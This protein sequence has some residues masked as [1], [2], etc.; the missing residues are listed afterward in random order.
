MLC[1]R[2]AIEKGRRGGRAIR[3][4]KIT[5]TIVQPLP[6]VL[7]EYRNSNW[8]LH[9]NDDP[10]RAVSPICPVMD[11]R[12]LAAPDGDCRSW[13]LGEFI[14]SNA[15]V[16]DEILQFNFW[17]T[18]SLVGEIANLPSVSTECILKNQA[19]D[20]SFM[21]KQLTLSVMASKVS[22]SQHDP[23]LDISHR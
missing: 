7:Y 20:H 2:G 21:R 19:S 4:C 8:K 11:V 14:G 10:T 6:L 15:A 1:A 9:S 23:S 22:S 3:A 17:A 18:Q 13:F 12:S 16:K 5:C